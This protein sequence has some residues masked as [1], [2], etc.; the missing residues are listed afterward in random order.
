M[1][2]AEIA[3]IVIAGCSLVLAG[4]AIVVAFRKADQ[5]RRQVLDSAP[6]PLTREE[7]IAQARGFIAAC[8][9]AEAALEEHRGDIHAAIMLTQHRDRAAQAREQLRLLGI[10]P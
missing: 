8:H 2:P 10:E 6:R 1:T 5:I 3:A 7:R 9:G 4:A